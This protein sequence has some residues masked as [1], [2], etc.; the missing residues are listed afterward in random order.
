MDGITPDCESDIGCPIPRPRSDVSR[1][2]DLLDKLAAL[3][4]LGV[5]NRVLDLYQATRWD[6]ELMV[7]ARK[8]LNQKDDDNGDGPEMDTECAG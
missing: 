5:G 1:A 8:T 7:T 2:L 4:D 3:K 6:I